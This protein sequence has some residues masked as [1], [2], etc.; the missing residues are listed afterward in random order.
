[1]GLIRRGCTHEW[2][3]SAEEV[4]CGGG[5]WACN[6]VLGGVDVGWSHGLGGGM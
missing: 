5:M 4:G 1:M 3:W 2:R 6:V